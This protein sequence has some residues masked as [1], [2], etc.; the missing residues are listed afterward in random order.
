MNHSDMDQRM[1]TILIAEDN[2][3]NLKLASVLLTKAGHAVLQAADGDAA[4]TMAR[5]RQP[6]LVLMD[7]QMAGMD[8]LAANRALK[9]DEATRTIPVVALTAFA[10]RGDQEKIMAAGC[11]GY[12]AKP[13]RYGE[14]L[15]RVEE[16]LNRKKPA[17]APGGAA[18]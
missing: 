1:A 14:L 8:G 15:R 5:T 10:M 18:T 4:V 7:V 13:Y 11:D 2:P 17:Q 16:F 6:D 12:I 3:V 9:Q